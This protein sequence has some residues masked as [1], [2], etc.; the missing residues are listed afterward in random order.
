[1]LSTVQYALGIE[2]VLPQFLNYYT[3]DTALLAPT[4]TDLQAELD[5]LQVVVQAYGQEISIQKTKVLVVRGNPANTVAQQQQSIYVAGTELEVVSSF[6][7]LG[8]IETS[9][10]TMDEEITIR[11]QKMEHAISVYS[12]N[13]FKNPIIALKTKLRVYE[14]MVIPIALY[15]AAT[16]NASEAQLRKLDSCQYKALLQILGF[17]WYDQVSYLRIVKRLQ[18]F[19]VKC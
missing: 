9:Q 7:Y 14:T 18:S 3:D 4:A 16:W 13:V 11:T 8:S 5:M 17:K 10:A 2:R 19:G 15:G 6:K 1:M 12:D